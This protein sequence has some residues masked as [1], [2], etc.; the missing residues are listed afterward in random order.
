MNDLK[1]LA[2]TVASLAKRNKSSATVT[3]PVSRV[4][5]DEED[6]AAQRPITRS[7]TK[8][9]TRLRELAARALPLP[10][11]CRIATPHLG[12]DGRLSNARPASVLSRG[13]PFVP[14]GRP[15]PI[16]CCALGSELD[17]EN[18]VLVQRAKV[19]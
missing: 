19:N 5:E 13:D 2:Q 3:V 15:P 16:V 1:R 11:R 12:E 8:A 4:P 14:F 9:A 10:T 17:T 18:V 6:N 7:Q